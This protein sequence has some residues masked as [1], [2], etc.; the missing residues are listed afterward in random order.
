MLN[1]NT[2]NTQTSPRFQVAGKEFIYK[3]FDA[4]LKKTV[5]ED[6]AIDFSKP[7]VQNED[8]TVEFVGLDRS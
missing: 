1:T 2:A 5:I 3:L 6:K 8:G 4:F 7:V